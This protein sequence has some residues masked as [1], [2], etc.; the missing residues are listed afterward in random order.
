MYE[1]KLA[2]ILQDPNHFQV[3][4]E[5]EEEQEIIFEEAEEILRKTWSNI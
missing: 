3:P 2:H 5:T 1:N 4:H